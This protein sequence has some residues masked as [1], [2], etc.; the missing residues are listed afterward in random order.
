MTCTLWLFEMPLEGHRGE[1]LC[2]SESLTLLYKRAYMSRWVFGVP[3]GGRCCPVGSWLPLTG[4]LIGHLTGTTAGEGTHN[5]TGHTLR[6]V[7]IRANNGSDNAYDSN[8]LFS[9]SSQPDT[10]NNPLPRSTITILAKQILHKV[11]N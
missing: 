7:A 4:G 9:V 5:Q 3:Q 10:T 2:L 1:L 11:E 6:Y 8:G